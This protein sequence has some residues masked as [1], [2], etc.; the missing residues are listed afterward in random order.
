MKTKRM[1]TKFIQLPRLDL[2]ADRT[3]MRPI[4]NYIYLTRDVIVAT[5]THCFVEF[6]TT[7]LF[8][9]SFISELPDYP[10]LIHWKQWELFAKKHLIH[11]LD[12]NKNIRI[13]FSDNYSVIIPTT[14]ENKEN[15][16][17]PDYSSIFPDNHKY[18]NQ[19]KLNPKLL[20]KLSRALNLSVFD[21]KLNGDHGSIQIMD[22]ELCFRALISQSIK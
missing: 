1:K 21:M 12:K 7:E 2:I 10:L 17:Y 4:L 14:T 5:D 11:S 8:H 9:F 16:S 18:T 15:I 13:T 19:I 6:K 22:K 3:Q 20:Y